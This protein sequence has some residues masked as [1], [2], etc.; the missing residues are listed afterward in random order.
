VRRP[1]ESYP[2]VTDLLLLSGYVMLVSRFMMSKVDNVEGLYEPKIGF[3]GFAIFSASGQLQMLR[4][5]SL[6]TRRSKVVFDDGASAVKVL[7]N[8]PLT[9]EVSGPSSGVRVFEWDRRKMRFKR[10]Q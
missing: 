9:I 8:A 3:T 7:K 1:R 2:K 5:V 10:K 4:V 6:G